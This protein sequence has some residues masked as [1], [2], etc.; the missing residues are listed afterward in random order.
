[1]SADLAAA[2]WSAQADLGTRL[3]YEDAICF[4][5]VLMSDPGTRTGARV[6]GLRYPVPMPDLV[7]M[8]STG[9]PDGLSPFKSADEM[10]RDEGFRA[11]ADEE[12]EALSRMS[13][14]WGGA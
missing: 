8:C 14:I 9:V 3:R 13:P 1:M 2:G 7:A 11:T 5:S 10:R 6:L 4:L 12:E